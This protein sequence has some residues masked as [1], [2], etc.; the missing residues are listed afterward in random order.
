[1]SFLTSV[2]AFATPFVK[3]AVAA[4]PVAVARS[5]FAVVADEQIKL[6]NDKKDKGFWFAS[7]D[8]ALVVSLKNGAAVLPQCVFRV[9]DAAD[10][11]KLLDAAK[12]SCAAG[13]FDDM[14]KSTARAPRK[15]AADVAAPAAPAQQTLET[16]APVAP[17]ASPIAAPTA[18]SKSKRK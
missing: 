2:S 15:P 1:M 14:F 11:I 13:E 3:S 6:L 18:A 4:D 8:G 7:K 16:P 12:K 17:A 5:K 10:A 9:K